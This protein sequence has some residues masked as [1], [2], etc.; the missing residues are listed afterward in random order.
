MVEEKVPGNPWTGGLT[1][2]SVRW[3]A[4]KTLDVGFDDFSKSKIAAEI[5][6]RVI[7]DCILQYTTILDI[8]RALTWSAFKSGR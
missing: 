5:R 7:V 8:D 4:L 2:L 1:D 3:Q 6:R